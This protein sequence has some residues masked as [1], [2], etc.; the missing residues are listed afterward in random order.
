MN[1]TT[2]EYTCLV[3]DCVGN[4]TVVRVKTTSRTHAQKRIKVLTKVFIPQSQISEKR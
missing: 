4:Q 3:T 1:K 2:K